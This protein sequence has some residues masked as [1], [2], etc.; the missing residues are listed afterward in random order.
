MLCLVYFDGFQ[1]EA[2]GEIKKYSVELNNFS[3][4]LEKNNKAAIRG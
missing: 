3:E 4:S 2:A 1:K